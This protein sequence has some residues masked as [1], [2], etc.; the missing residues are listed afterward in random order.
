MAPEKNF[1]ATFYSHFD[2]LTFFNYLKGKKIKA[3]LMPVPRKVSASCGT[4][5]SYITDSDSEIDYTVSEIE[6][7]YHITADGLLVVFSNV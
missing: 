2:A 1:I 7:V 5:V 6:A 4:C 3:K